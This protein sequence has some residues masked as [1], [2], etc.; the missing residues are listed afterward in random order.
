MNTSCFF[1][2]L[3][4]DPNYVKWENKYFYSILDDCPVTPG[5]SLIIP[6]RHIDGFMNLQDEEWKTLKDG[7]REVIEMIEMTG[8][9]EH[10]KSH[11]KDWPNRFIKQAIK[12]TTNNPKPTAYNH[13]VN[14]G[15]AAGR[16]V[17]HIIPRYE[18]DMKDPTGGVRHVIP[19]NGN[20]R[21]ST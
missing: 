17:G 14:D 2:K 10:Y 4:K 1:C 18:G 8:L 21:T 6:K 7:L 19:G 20:Y 12:S 5:H 9:H 15:K 16:T 13:G 11:F 3:F